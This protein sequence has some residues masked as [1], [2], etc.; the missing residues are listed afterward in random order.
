VIFTVNSQSPLPAAVLCLL[1]GIGRRLAHC[2]ENPYSLLTDW[3][4]DLEIVAPIRH[5]VRRQLDLLAA[6]GLEPPDE[7]LSI[8]VPDTA[9]RLPFPEPAALA[10]VAPLLI[11]NT[12]AP[13]HLAAAV[14]TPV[15]DLY[16]LT[17]L[18][19]TPWAVPSRIL[20][21]DVPCRGCLRSVCPLGHN[22]C[23]R[24]VEPAEIVAATLDLAREVGLVV[25][26]PL[27]V[28]R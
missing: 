16:A 23:L 25:P 8:R 26:E 11:T 24:G 13:A 14:G 18:Q 2:R 17:N 9:G 7:H 19:H 15:V 3:V 5:E 27:E 28:A 10:A 1:A 4:P 12:P 20:S 22:R 6:V 21:V